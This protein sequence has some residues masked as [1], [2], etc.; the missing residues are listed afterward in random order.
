[1]GEALQ[2]SRY[3]MFSSGAWADV[4]ERNALH[5]ADMEV[6]GAVMMVE[7][8]RGMDPSVG[9]LG[10]VGINQ[11]HLMRDVFFDNVFTDMAFH[12]EIKKSAARVEQASV[13]LEGMVQEARERQRQVEEE[14]VWRE[15]EV[16]AAREALQKVREMAFE[17][18]AESQ[19]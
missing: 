1:M 2:A 12:E 17:S 16:K 8:A 19:K 6:Q 18:F 7:R 15:R 11:G 5:R 10:D 9:G 4:M 3:D 13:M 14:L